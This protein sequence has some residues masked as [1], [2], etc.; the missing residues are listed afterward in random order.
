MLVKTTLSNLLQ[1]TY[2]IRFQRIPNLTVQD[3]LEID[4]LKT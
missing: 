4:F 2:I 3:D 1:K